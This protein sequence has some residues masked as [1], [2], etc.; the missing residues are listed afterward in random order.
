M[1]VTSWNSLVKN[2]EDILSEYHTKY[3]LRKGAPK[4]FLRN[5]LKIKPSQHNEILNMLHKK[6]IIIEETSTIRLLSHSPKL[7]DVQNAQAIQFVD[8]LTKD[9]FS[10]HDLIGNQILE[11][12]IDQEKVIRL[13]DKIVFSADVYQE[14]VKVIK[15]I[16]LKHDEITVAKLRDEFNTSRKYAVAILDYMDQ[17]QVTKRV[18]DVRILR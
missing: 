14:I 11:F 3:P 8:M 17:Q 12:L 9:P 6:N 15:E 5:Q 7:S 2:T 1:T 10:P 4:E 13:D 16:L 18:G